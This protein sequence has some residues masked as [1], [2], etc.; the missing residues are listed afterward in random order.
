MTDADVVVHISDD[1]DSKKE[2]AMTATSAYNA[3]VPAVTS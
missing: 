3:V 2:M 1:R